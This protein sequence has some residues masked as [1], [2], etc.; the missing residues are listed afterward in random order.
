MVRKIGN[1]KGKIKN[2][3]FKM[4]NRGLWGMVRQLPF[5]SLLEVFYAKGG[6]DR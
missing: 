1:V 3:S 5:V 4:L 6:I 2:G